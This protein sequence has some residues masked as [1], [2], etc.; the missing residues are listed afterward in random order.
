MRMSR[1]YKIF[2]LGFFLVLTPAYAQENPAV[3]ENDLTDL[4][5]PQPAEVAAAPTPSPTANSL[6]I[7]QAKDGG[8][9]SI[10]LGNKMTS[11]MLDEQESGNLERAVD[12]LKSNQV[13]TPEGSEAPEATNAD[14]KIAAAEAEK[15]RQLEEA[16][17]RES[18]RSYIYLAS[19]I[20]FSPKDWI[21]WINDKK[22]TSKT[23]DSKKELS[24]QSITRDQVKILWKL[25]LSKWR[26]IS[27]KKEE[28]AP[29]TNSENQIELRFTLKP[30]QTFVL[31]SNQVVEGQ[32]LIALLKQ[33]EEDKKLE[34]ATPAGVPA[35]ALAITPK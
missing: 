27:G 8:L 28:L 3:K 33:K 18:E 16:K 6:L 24:V 23:N 10:L 1:I 34:Q 29:K 20:Y 7:D 14:P 15:A 31:S 19:I 13:Y 26:V 4:S 5:Q 22:I 11:L 35:P 32:A 30:N 21:V 9:V 25:S 2:F 12:A 17:N